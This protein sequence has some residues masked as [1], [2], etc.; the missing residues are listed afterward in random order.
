MKKTEP[1]P[2]HLM[3]L[4]AKDLSVEEMSFLCK[5]LD[6]ITR[7]FIINIYEKHCNIIRNISM[8]DYDQLADAY[9]EQLLPDLDTQKAPLNLDLR[10]YICYLR[11]LGDRGDDARSGTTKAFINDMLKMPEIIEKSEKGEKQ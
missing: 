9:E 5:Q 1:N 3:A 10:E 2:L 8:D 11:L 7:N 6:D 4:F